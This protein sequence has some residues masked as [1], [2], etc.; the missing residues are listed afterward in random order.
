MT[1]PVGVRALGLHQRRAGRPT[2]ASAA[3]RARRAA[4]GRRRGPR[5]VSQRSLT[6]PGQPPPG[7]AW[8]AG[9]ASRRRRWAPR[10]PPQRAG[11]RGDLHQ[12]EHPGRP[13]D[14]GAG[15]Q[16][17]GSGLPPEGRG[18]PPAPRPRPPA[19]A[20][21]AGP[22]TT[23]PTA[24]RASVVTGTV[25]RRRH[26][27]E[28]HVTQSQG[29]RSQ[30]WGRQVPVEARGIRSCSARAQGGGAGSRSTRPTGSGQ[31]RGQL[32]SSTSRGTEH[33]HGH[34]GQRERAAA[35]AVSSRRAGSTGNDRR[36]RRASARRCAWCRARCRRVAAQPP[37]ARRAQRL[38][39]GQP[40][41]QGHGGRW[42]ASKQAIWA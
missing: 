25:N 19:C 16:P 12:Q 28:G 31:R 8:P 26:E 10:A 6:D 42:A 34:E 40:H 11:A 38:P 1:E 2:A 18:S 17:G 29:R 35:A 9:S 30:L 5:R 3:G 4:G 13:I 36:E 22:A 41:H 24:A 33:G 27:G 7:R 39:V 20:A 14:V 15:A 21:G 23:P 32:A 37:P